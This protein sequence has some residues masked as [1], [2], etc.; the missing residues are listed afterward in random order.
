MR[1]AILREI[2]APLTI[3]DV[4]LDA[5]RPDEV[6]V[7][8]AASG[9]CHSD[10]HFMV[11]DMPY[12]L[13]AVLGHEASGVVESVGSNVHEFR[14]GDRVVTCISTFCGECGQCQSGHSYRCDDRPSRGPGAE[15]A[16]IHQ[17]ATPINQFSQLGGFAGEMLVHRH[18]VVK[19]PDEMPLDL[20]SLLGCAVLTGVGAVLNRAQV[21]PGQTVAVVGCGGVGLNVIQGAK[22]AGAGR[23]VAVDLNPSKL[24][25]ARQ[26]G[27]T[28]VVP[29]GD[30]AVDAVQQ[31][32]GG[33]D[34]AFEVI[35]LQSTVRQAFLMLRKGGAAVL[36]GVPKFGSDVSVPA[37]PFL[38]KEVRLISSMMGSVPFQVAIPQYAQMY[39]D[40]RLALEP[41]VSQRI[42]LDEINRGYDDLAKGAVA[43]SVIMFS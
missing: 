6:R 34:Y 10:Y 8:V 5:P 12:P 1:A 24:E 15:N 39:L 19:L 29:G 4:E 22:I 14:P 20:A 18:S 7:R 43:R 33:V 41:L 23:I 9:L 31:L 42:S 3:E 40:G 16:R 35:G 17:G 13:P 2:G 30:D 11:G 21:K 32:T 37:L 25:L 38:Q 36:V 26:F 28:D 27:A